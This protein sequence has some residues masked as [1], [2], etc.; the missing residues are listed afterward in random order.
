MITLFWFLL[1][2]LVGT[3]V[4]EFIAQKFIYNKEDKDG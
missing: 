2:G 4:G 3:F 1:G